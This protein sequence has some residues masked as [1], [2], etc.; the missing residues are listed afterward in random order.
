MHY[1]THRYH[2]MKKHKFGVMYLGMLFM[3][4]SLAPREYEK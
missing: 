2:R 3:E 4:T 1:L